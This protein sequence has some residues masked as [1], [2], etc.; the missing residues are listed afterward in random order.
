MIGLKEVLAPEHFAALRVRAASHHELFD[1]PRRAS[2][3]PK[4]DAVSI[5][6]ATEYQ[7]CSCCPNGAGYELFVEANRSLG[8]WDLA[9]RWGSVGFWALR[10]VRAYLT[11]PTVRAAVIDEVAANIEDLRP[12]A[13]IGHSLG[14]VVTIE[15]LAR[16]DSKHE[17]KVL[18]T[19]GA[20]FAW[21]RFTAQWS[22]R[23]RAWMSDP[24]PTWLNLVDLS[25][26]VTASVV[27]ATETYGG[28]TH[29]VVDND[30]LVNR[31]SWWRA[32]MDGDAAHDSTHMARHYLSHPPVA[33]VFAAV[34][35]ERG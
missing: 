31:K 30:H 3:W 22:G 23:A 6:S 12:E 19:A 35:A 25:D 27:P 28:A 2:T 7:R 4:V 16:A 17:P 21:P 14:S 11:S 20:P 32:V 24:G 8:Y 1:E 10:D 5:E 9:W 18:I 33:E 34:L 15:A 29:V 13:V 26:P